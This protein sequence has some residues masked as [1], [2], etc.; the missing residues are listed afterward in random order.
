MSINKKTSIVS[1][2]LVS[3]VLLSGCGLF[4]SQGKKRSIRQKQYLTPMKA[5]VLLRKQQE[6]KQLKMKRVLR[7]ILKQSFT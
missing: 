1:A 5:K 7:Q 4:G 2:V 6:K 3:S